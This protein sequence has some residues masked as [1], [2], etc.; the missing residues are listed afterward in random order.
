M[1]ESLKE[2]KHRPVRTA[3]Y[4][5]VSSEEQAEYGCS[6]R[7]QKERC[8]AYIQSHPEL[9]LQGCYIDDGISGQKLEREEF[10]R[11]MDE[12]KKGNIDLILFTKLDRWFRSLRHYLNTQ[13]VLEEKNVGW[14][15]LDQPYFDT[16]T[17]YGK[18]FVAQSMTWAELEAQNGGQRVRDVFK[19]KVA[20][21]EAIT[22]KVPR[23]YRLEEKHLVLSEEAPALADAIA[24]FVHTQS[25]GEAIRYLRETYGIIMTTGN[26]R[27]SLLR[28][29]KITGRYRGNDHYC[30]RLISEELWNQVQDILNENRNIRTSQTYPYLF[31][32]LLVC[33]TCG[34]KMYACQIHARSV[35]ADGT[36]TRYRYPAYE[37]SGH[38]QKLCTNK[39][40]IRE[41]A[42][43]KELLRTL[44][45]IFDSVIPIVHEKSRPSCN[46]SQRKKTL[47]QKISRLNELYVNGFLSLESYQN[48]RLELEKM[49]SALPTLCSGPSDTE[50]S[51]LSHFLSEG[52]ETVY[53]LLKNEEKRRFWRALIKKIQISEKKDGSFHM[54]ITFL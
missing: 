35:K 42:I 38:R 43:E 2:E 53:L 19:T 8:L 52:F 15:A 28:N 39:R 21:G 26:F 3:V 4:I 45:P 51:K 16:T 50:S 7:D 46:L 25:M 23:G 54:S 29:E 36:V 13:A 22:G 24:C 18:A 31:S 49:I 6:I 27:Q 33:Q 47:E 1:K 44:S 11:L 40:V 48:S 14:T 37:C 12:V 34:R 30:P 10:N 9:V 20:H 41:Q 5:R 32:G 17:P